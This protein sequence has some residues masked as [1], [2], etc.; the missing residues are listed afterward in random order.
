MGW[1]VSFFV[2]TD[3][4]WLKRAC[5]ACRKMCQGTSTE[6][7]GYHAAEHPPMPDSRRDSASSDAR[8]HMNHRYYLSDKLL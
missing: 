8:R 7:D 2:T 6:C 1:N 5:Q 4:K 3:A